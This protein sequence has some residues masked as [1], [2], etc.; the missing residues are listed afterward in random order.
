MSRLLAFLAILLLASVAVAQTT[1]VQGLSNGTPVGISPSGGT[2][3]EQ[4]ACGT[5][6]CLNLNT[7]STL[8]L[9]ANAKR[10]Q[11]LLQNTGTTPL[12]CAHSTP[13]TTRHFILKASTATSTGDGLSYTCNQGPGTY[14]G[15]I[16][17]LSFATSTNSSIDVSAIGF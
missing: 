16:S 1:R 17:C 12:F 8:V 15:A 5:S 9:S 10:F 14:L 6:P 13:T 7:T 4:P 3:N 11:C 2:V